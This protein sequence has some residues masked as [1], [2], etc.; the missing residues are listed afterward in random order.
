V[1]VRATGAGSFGGYSAL[2]D[3]EPTEWLRLLDA[4]TV[5]V[6]GFFR[7]DAVYARL[8]ADVLPALAAAQ[9][10]PLHAWSAGCASGE[11][12][13]TVAML[14]ADIA[15]LDRTAVLATDIDVA[16]LARAT[17]AVYPEILTRDIPDDLRHAWWQGTESLRAVDALRARVEFREHNL[18]SDVPPR[19]GLHLITCRNVI[20]YFSRPAQEQLF[21]QFADALVPGGI[22]VLGKVEMLSGPARARFEAIDVRERIY[23]RV[24]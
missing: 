4:L 13:W 2:L 7:D 1:R 10:G 16:S 19:T 14:L 11:E 8:R 24:S 6:T 21:T 18:F 15:G 22:L 23:R 9:A 20:I 5:N 17:A 3:R 12:A